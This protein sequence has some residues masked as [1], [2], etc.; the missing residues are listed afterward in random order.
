MNDKGYPEDE[1]TDDK[2]VGG[3][4]KPASKSFTHYVIQMTLDQID[5]LSDCLLAIQASKYEVEKNTIASLAFLIREKTQNIKNFMD[6]VSKEKR[7]IVLGERLS[8][9]PE[10]PQPSLGKPEAKNLL[11]AAIMRWYEK[12]GKKLHDS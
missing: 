12:E 11:F 1:F 3:S 9:E 10:E 6:E 8:R 5:A 2:V 4:N 7:S